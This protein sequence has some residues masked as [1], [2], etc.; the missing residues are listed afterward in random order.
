MLLCLFL[1]EE[2][3]SFFVFTLFLAADSWSAVY[4]AAEAAAAHNNAFVCEEDDDENEGIGSSLS[5]EPGGGL[6]CLFLD[7][8]A[9]SVCI[10]FF[11]GDP[12]D[13]VPPWL[14]VAVAVL[15]SASFGTRATGVLLCESVCPVASVCGGW[16]TLPCLMRMRVFAGVCAG[17]WRVLWCARVGAV[18]VSCLIAFAFL[19]ASAC[20]SADSISEWR[21]RACG[22]CTSGHVRC[23]STGPCFF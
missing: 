16:A 13:P 18:C 8:E 12:V 2:T 9:A 4:C 5:E 3:A 10:L 20:T 14:P 6:L 21:Y 17:A 7:G 23:V 15:A 19:S 1:Q 22:V 11:A